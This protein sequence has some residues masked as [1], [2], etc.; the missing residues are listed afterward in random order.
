MKISELCRDTNDFSTAA[1]SK[2]GKNY[3]PHLDSETLEHTHAQKI[4]EHRNLQEGRNLLPWINLL[5]HPQKPLQVHNDESPQKQIKR[6]DWRNKFFQQFLKS[7]LAQMDT[8]RVSMEQSTQLPL[9]SEPLLTFNSADDLAVQTKANNSS[10]SCWLLTSKPSPGATCQPGGF[11][12][13][14]DRISAIGL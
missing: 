10:H 12:Q 13:G 11:F 9:P 7:N 5:S 14:R 6:T 3:D 8:C 1:S 4:H 2:T